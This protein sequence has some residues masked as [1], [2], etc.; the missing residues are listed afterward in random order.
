MHEWGGEYK[1]GGRAIAGHRNIPN[2]TEAQKGLDI[3]V[4]GLGLHWVP[5]KDQD[6]NF[7]F[8]DHGANLLIAAQRATEQA[9]YF[10]VECFFNEAACGTCGVELVPFQN[11]TIVDSPLNEVVF[12]M[13]VCN[14][15]DALLRLKNAERFAHGSD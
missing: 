6:I 9:S 3:G 11:I 13:V 12:F 5:E 7:T 1:I 8:R 10:L 4:V 15:R 2:G 14:Q